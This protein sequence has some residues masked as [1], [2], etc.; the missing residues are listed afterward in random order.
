MK[1]LLLLALSALLLL[2]YPVHAQPGDSGQLAIAGTDGNITL[3]DMAA[4]TTTPVTQDAVPGVSLYSWPTWAVD[5]Q[6]A[7]FGANL[8]TVPP[9]RFGIFIRDVNGTTRRVYTSPDETFTY[10]H[11][12]PGECPLGNCRDLAVL[13]TT[14]DQGLAVRRV[15]SL[16]GGTDYE[17]DEVAAGA[18]FYWDWSPDGQLMFWA[19]FG[20]SL[21]IYDTTR[22]E[23][24]HTF[25]ETQGVQ[26]SVDW[27]P[28]DDRLLSTV[29]AGNF[30]SNLVVFHGD[31]R[32]VLAEG[33]AGNV[34]FEWSPDGSQV[35]YVDDSRGEL[36]VVTA[37]TGATV[38]TLPGPALAFFWSP[39][40]SQIAYLSFSTT[41]DDVPAK[42]APQAIPMIQW[43]V[44]HVA[45]G[46]TNRYASFIPTRDMI[47]CLS[48]YDQ[49]AHSH[50]LWSPDSRYLTYGEVR[51]DSGAVVS[52][53]DTHTPGSP[54][55]TVMEGTIGIFSW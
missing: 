12:S 48:F 8:A 19:R 17:V 36:T 25:E 33:L 28:V 20:R 41:L 51:Q 39:D 6:L 55:Q 23:V 13:Y 53:I 50:R 10:A 30:T 3:Y 27:S 24:I 15:R 32:L 11:W 43:Y 54:P 37:A 42:P 29:R 34:V 47:Y 35:A 5:G 14:A 21:E 46:V 22:E 18:P 38:A 52:V 31:E 1:A 9:F 26:R 2:P 16:N 45:D 44:Y 4:G 40:G 49:F 7:Y